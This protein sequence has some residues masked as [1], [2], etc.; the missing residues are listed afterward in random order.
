MNFHILDQ[1]FN[2][3]K[4]LDSYK[5][6][7]WTD[8]YATYGDFELY[9]PAET[10]KLSYLK[11]DN[12]IWCAE[13]E[14]LMIIESVD[15]QTSSEDGDFFIVTGRSLESILDR[16]I[17]WG[18]ETIN[19]NLQNGIKTLIDKN[20]IAS[21][22]PNRNIPNFIFQASTD[23]R[24]TSLTL[25]AQY[26][27]DNLYDV[28]SGVCKEHDIG[29]KIILNSEN[30][31]VFSLYAGEDRSFSQDKNPYVVF[32]PTYENLFSSNRRQSSKDVKNTALVYGEGEKTVSVGLG[33]GLARKEIA[34]DASDVQKETSEGPISD[35]EYE[36]ILITRGTEKLTETKPIDEFDCEVDPYGVFRYREDFFIG[37]VVQ[38]ED[39][40][41]NQGKSRITEYIMSSDDS[42]YSE[43]PTFEMVE[44]EGDGT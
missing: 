27:G 9:T 29:F 6:F 19:G 24:I 7:I 44:K 16:R 21:V 18:S 40:Y 3:I 30:K 38:I 43:Y 26:I 11:E 35:E 15:I 12:Y 17:V 42:G 4:V 28:I 41:K 8:R 32:S 37:D 31:F 23:T 36:K 1:N 14:H 34:V 10:S 22:W 5:S 25:S 20:I 33:K 39:G 13:S 2:A